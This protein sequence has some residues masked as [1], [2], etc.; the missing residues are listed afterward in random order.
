M[1]YFYSTYIQLIKKPIWASL[2]VCHRLTCLWPPLTCLNAYRSCAF[3]RTALF[4]TLLWQVFRIVSKTTLQRALC[5]PAKWHQNSDFLSWSIKK[6]GCKCMEE[7]SSSQMGR[8]CRQWL[9]KIRICCHDSDYLSD[10]GSWM[11]FQQ[12][13]LFQVSSSYLM[14]RIYRTAEWFTTIVSS[15]IFRNTWCWKFVVIQ[16][17]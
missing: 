17:D 8:F 12:C 1:A 16:C 13:G 15:F 6:E 9:L 3:F 11:V 4:A 10:S 14:L 2:S 7:N 5:S